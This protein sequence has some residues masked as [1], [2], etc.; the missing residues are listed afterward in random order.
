MIVV[1]AG[2]FVVSVLVAVAAVHVV[3]ACTPTYVAGVIDVPTQRQRRGRAI[4]DRF[5]PHLHLSP[6]S[7][8]VPTLVASSSSSTTITSVCMLS[9]MAAR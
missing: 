9:T 7:L 3:R 8:H 5:L 2:L 1:V 6:F 4:E